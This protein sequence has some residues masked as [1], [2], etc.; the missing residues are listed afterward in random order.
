MF[1]L[2]LQA[3]QNRISTIY[4]FWV[5]PKKGNIRCST[6]Y[7][8]LN[9]MSC[10]LPFDAH[11]IFWKTVVVFISSKHLKALIISE[12]SRDRTGFRI[13]VLRKRARSHS[14]HT[15]L[16]HIHTALRKRI[17]LHTQRIT[18]SR[19][20]RPNSTIL[21]KMPFLYFPILF[22]H[23][24]L[25][26][27]LSATLRLLCT[28]Y[29]SWHWTRSFRAPVTVAPITSIYRYRRQPFL[30]ARAHAQCVSHRLQR[31]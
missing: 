17:I 19:N 15:A 29:I 7:F 12:N 28:I 6:I 13:S 30:N 25:S 21:I 1:M 14:A 31:M 11:A 26:P 27:S 18:K 9:A 8:R 22:L 3:M 4:L 24:T 23:V 10:T 2:T 20:S 16:T 5:W